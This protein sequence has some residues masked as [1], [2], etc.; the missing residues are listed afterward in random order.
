MTLIPNHNWAVVETL[1]E[2]LEAARRGSPQVSASVH[3]FDGVEALK[4]AFLLDDPDVDILILALAP[5]MCPRVGWLFREH[6]AGGSS[7][8]PGVDLICELLRL[9]PEEIVAY[10]NRVVPHAPLIARGLL[11]EATNLP[12]APLVP[13]PRARR[14]ILGL[15]PHG[16][17]IPG[18][19][20]IQPDAYSHTLERLVCPDVVCQQLQELASWPEHEDQLAQWGVPVEHGPVVLFAGASGTGKTMAAKALAA[21]AGLPLYRVDMGLLVSKYIGDTPKN[22]NELFR[23]ARRTEAVL[24]F[25]EAEGLFGKRGEVKEARDRYANMEVGHLL[26]RMEQHP[27][28][29]LL[30]TNLR[31]QID[32]AFLRRIDV[33]LNFTFPD[34]AQ[35]R[36][37]WRLYLNNMPSHTTELVHQLA[38]VPRLSGAQIAGA[39]R[40]A[41]HHLAFRAS[42]GWDQSSLLQAV[43]RGL[44][45][46][47]KKTQGRALRASLG[48]LEQHLEAEAA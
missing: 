1:V 17:E 20:L 35:R 10:R 37:L 39:C 36:D 4:T 12:Y 30:T 33:V 45:N 16:T 14:R 6:Q 48:F 7:S 21:E 25:D 15:L 38:S 46:E 18:A 23:H 26:A 32:P 40:Y 9:E 24:L 43:A 41:A 5:L 27:G 42:S 28:I 2:Q 29:C 3:P 34:E 44:W 47:L 8:F 31:D 22:I 19:V 11:E 13:T